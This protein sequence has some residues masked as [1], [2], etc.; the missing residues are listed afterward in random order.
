MELL[1]TDVLIDIQ[2]GHPPAVAWFSGLTEL[3]VVPGFVI[4]ELIQDARNAR[5]VRQTLRLI[6]PFQVVWPMET[7]CAAPSPISPPTTCRTVWAC[8]TR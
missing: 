5:E 6:A 3:P 7:D 4:M 1:D 8:W 2:R